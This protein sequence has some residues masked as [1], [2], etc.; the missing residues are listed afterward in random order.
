[1]A[2]QSAPGHADPRVSWQRHDAYPWLTIAG[3][4]GV[5]LTL[6]IAA[7]GLPTMNLHGPL[8]SLG[9]MDP[10]C[11]GT[12]AAW[13]TTHGRLADAWRYNPLG[14]G[15]VAGAFLVLA[16]TA[17]GVA[18]GRWLTLTWTPPAR[19]RRG[20]ILVALALLAALEIR[21]QG[22]ADLLLTVTTP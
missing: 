15:A 16:R 6:A 14:I 11:G 13:L 18:T 2:V 5:L 8:H 7:A 3:L 1:M 22:R 17:V 12:R 20:L 10:L 21:Q 4:G 9:I 19:T